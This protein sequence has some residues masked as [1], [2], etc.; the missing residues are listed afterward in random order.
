[1]ANTDMSANLNLSTVDGMGFE[2]VN[3]PVTSTAIISGTNLYAAGSLQSP[4]ISGTNIYA[5]TTVLSDNVFGDVEISGLLV[6]ANTLTATTGSITNL[7]M[8]GNIGFY[9][10]PVIAQPQ[11]EVNIGS[12]HAALV[13]IGLIGS[14]A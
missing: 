3:Q 1:M 4:W 14:I 10:T 6:T 9:D 13:N 5:T 12:V 8:V 7:H 2:E 11:V